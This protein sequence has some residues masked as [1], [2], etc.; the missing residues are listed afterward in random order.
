MTMKVKKVIDLLERNGWVFLR[1]RGDHRIFGKEGAR[2]PIVIPGN[3][4]DD[5]K[6]G[7]L[8]SIL[9]EAGLK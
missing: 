1:M 5:L 3:L 7:T 9:R 6:D 8:A 4:N 2:R